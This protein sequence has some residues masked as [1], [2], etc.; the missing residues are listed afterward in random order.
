VFRSDL[1]NASAIVY[2]GSPL[3]FPYPVDSSIDFRQY[4]V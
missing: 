3:L 4:D 1:G 2:E